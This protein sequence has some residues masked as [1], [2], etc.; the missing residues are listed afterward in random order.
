MSERLSIVMPVYNE[1]AVVAHVVGELTQEVT[2]SL[3]G[4]QM[5]LVD[6]GST[7]GTGAILDELARA[8]D[9][10]TVI[11]ADR[12]R[13]HGP[14]LR[15]GFDASD[16]DWIFQIDSDGQQ[17]AAEFWKLWAERDH[18][19]LV[20]G[21]R[22]TRE[23]GRHRAAVSAAARW[24]NRLV[25]GGDI[26][27]VN[28]PFKLFRR[29]VWDDVRPDVPAQP[30]APSI[31]IALGA[32]LR[33][34]RVA[35]VSITHLPRRGGESTVNLRALLR[36]SWGALREVL[37]FRPRIRRRAPLPSQPSSRSASAASS[38]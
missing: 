11:H 33:G 12:N 23:D 25:G 26:R 36:L 5:V 27:D 8:D 35:Q 2:N 31:L 32:S 6:D 15:A 28:V 13:G 34:W 1:S 4:A 9:R 21:V 18:A 20:M 24:V 10:I 14:S 7:D 22:R 38:L 29:I 19:D 3:E 17:V 16:G 30:V 37:R